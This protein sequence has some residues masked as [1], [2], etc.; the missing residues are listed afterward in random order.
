MSS[1]SRFGQLF[2]DSSKTDFDRQFCEMWMSSLTKFIRAC[3]SSVYFLAIFLVLED[4]IEFSRKLTIWQ[5]FIL[6]GSSTMSL[7]GFSSSFMF[8]SLFVMVWIVSL[9]AVSVVSY[10]GGL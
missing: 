6:L 9:N 7:I 5:K 8:V 10:L 3:L 2:Y 4:P 1:S